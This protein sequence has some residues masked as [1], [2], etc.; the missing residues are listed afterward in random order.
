[1]G[2]WQAPMSTLTEF[3]FNDKIFQSSLD[4]VVRESTECGV[5]KDTQRAPVFQPPTSVLCAQK[6]QPWTCEA[7]TECAGSSQEYNKSGCMLCLFYQG[8]NSRWRL[9]KYWE[10]T[11]NKYHCNCLSILPH[12]VFIIPT[13]QSAFVPLRTVFQR[14]RLDMTANEWYHYWALFMLFL[15]A[16]TLNSVQTFNPVVMTTESW[17]QAFFFFLIQI[18]EASVLICRGNLRNLTSEKCNSC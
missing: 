11:G 7:Q 16:P 8:T 1:M 5:T 14:W 9:E 3:W 13:T 17:Q 2:T 15:I 6:K 18:K 4:Y 10:V 12:N